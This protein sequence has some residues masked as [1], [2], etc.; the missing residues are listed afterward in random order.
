MIIDLTRRDDGGHNPRRHKLAD[1]LAAGYQNP[2]DAAPATRA[3]LGAVCSHTARCL[4]F[5]GTY[6]RD[7]TMFGEWIKGIK[8]PMTVYVASEGMIAHMP[9]VALRKEWYGFGVHRFY[10]DAAVVC[11][12]AGHF[13]VLGHELVAAGLQAGQAVQAHL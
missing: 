13:Q 1:D 10:P 5:L 11:V 6:G 7:L 12:K 3:F 9:D 2:Q 8:A 4:K